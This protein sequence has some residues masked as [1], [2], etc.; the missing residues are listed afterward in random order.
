LGDDDV[1]ARFSTERNTVGN[2]VF[3]AIDERYQPSTR[4]RCGASGSG[5]LGRLRSD[6]RLRHELRGADL[7]VVGVQDLDA[8]D[9]DLVAMNEGGRLDTQVDPVD[10]YIGALS[11]PP[12]HDS[13]VASQIEHRLKP[14]GG[15]VR[16]GDIDAWAGADLGLSRS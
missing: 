16:Y 14:E 2:L 15:V 10:A 4:C 13:V 6:I 8:A 5:A 9:F 11:R 12:D 1:R 7:L 3:L